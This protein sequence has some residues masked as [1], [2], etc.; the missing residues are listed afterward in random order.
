MNNKFLII[1]IIAIIAVI[2][3]AAAF[4]MGFGSNN[5]MSDSSSW[6]TKQLGDLKFKV[7]AK[8]E[9]GSMMSGNII[10]GIKSGDVYQSQ[11]L[12]ISINDT[13]WSSELDKLMN[14]SSADITI[15][16]IDGKDIKTFTTD[17]NSTA[18][19]KVNEDKIAINWSSKDINGDVKAIIASF[20]ELN[21]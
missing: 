9:N 3:I 7:P 20:F 15:I 12:S 19:F 8:Y 18:F 6:E 17:E 16:T 13:N 1:I 21:K 2:A 14:A 11:D 10:N 5:K 4:T